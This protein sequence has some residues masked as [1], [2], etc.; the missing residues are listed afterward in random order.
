MVLELKMNKMKIIISL[1][2]IGMVKLSLGQ[3]TCIQFNDSLDLSSDTIYISPYPN[4]VFFSVD[5]DYLQQSIPKNTVITVFI[6]FVQG[7]MADTCNK[8]VTFIINPSAVSVPE[9]NL[10]LLEARIFPNPM[11][12]A[13]VINISDKLNPDYNVIIY[14]SKGIKIYESEKISQKEFTLN[15]DLF[16]SSGLYFIELNSQKT[17]F[18]LIKLIVE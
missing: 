14:N 16:N 8:A 3:V 1:F 5:I 11:T 17:K 13:T 10:K 18:E 12:S 15:R 4:P 9:T 6:E 7:N 2:L